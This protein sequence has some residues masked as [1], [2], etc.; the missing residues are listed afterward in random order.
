MTDLHQE[1]AQPKRKWVD[2]TYEELNLLSFYKPNHPL[3]P[4]EIRERILVAI[5]TLKERNGG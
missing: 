4:Y 2:L 3:T 5:E 1:L